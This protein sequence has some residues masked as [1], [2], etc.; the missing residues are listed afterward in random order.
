MIND[1]EEEL[2]RLEKEL[3]ASINPEDDLISDLPAELLDTIC[4]GW[5]ELSPTDPEES[6]EITPEDLLDYPEEP[7]PIREP[8]KKDTRKKNKDTDKREDRVLTILMAIASFLCLG[9]IGILI[10][11]LEIFF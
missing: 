9:I 1:R 4:L 5:E 7:I 10:Y 3:L 8:A 6:L 11:W 2:Q